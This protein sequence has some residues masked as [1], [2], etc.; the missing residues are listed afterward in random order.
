MAGRS[1]LASAAYSPVEPDY[2]AAP[3]DT[4]YP[5]NDPVV[6][7]PETVKRKKR[8]IESGSFASDSGDVLQPSTSAALDSSQA[9]LLL[10][11]WRKVSRHASAFPF[12]RPVDTVLDGCPTYYDVIKNPMDLRTVREKLDANRYT[13]MDGFAADMRLM[14]ANCFAFNPAGTPVHTMGKEVEAA[15]EREWTKATTAALLS[16]KP[17][18]PSG[19]QKRQADLEME[20]AL[21]GSSHI[22]ATIKNIKIPRTKQTSKPVSSESSPG[23]SHLKLKV[24]KGHSASPKHATASSGQQS[25]SPSRQ[26]PAESLVSLDDPDTIMRYLD[27]AAGPTRGPPVSQDAMRVCARVLLRLQALPAAMEFMAPVDP[28]KQN[29]PTYFDIIKKPMDLGTIRK[30]LDRQKYRTAEEFRDDVQLV[31]HNCFLF[32]VPNT[33]VHTQG[34]NLQEAF[35]T[36]WTAHFGVEPQAPVSTPLPEDPPMSDREHARA[37]TML[38]KLKQGEHAWPFL[39]PV[40]PIALGVPTY[41][42]IVKNPMDFSTIQ[43]KLTKKV[44]RYVADFVCDLRLLLDDCFLF[45]LAETPVNEAGKAVERA[46]RAMLE[47]EGWARW[48]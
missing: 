33:Y 21:P 22:A 10:R 38:T 27:Q 34:L 13:S 4:Y 8:R 1:G 47:G 28:V 14:L 12:M 41:F 44:Y 25:A 32:N 43:R 2:S 29:V 9:K 20:N 30:K 5:V 35:R 15:F 7:P 37:R 11:V 36:A 16:A 42:A 45:N 6:A 40:D 26:G 19:K 31:L 3:P 46:A 48:F 17:A 24:S 18:R 23:S 39:K